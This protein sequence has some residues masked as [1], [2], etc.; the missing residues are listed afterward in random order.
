MAVFHSAESRWFFEGELPDPVRGWFVATGTARQEPTRTDD[1]LLLPGC[2]TT[3]VKIR[4]G[5]IEV[6]AMTR[7]SESVTYGRGVRG[8][9]D[10]WVKWS[11]GSQDVDALRRMLGNTGDRWLSVRK[12]RQLRLFSIASG[13]PVALDDP[14]ARIAGGCQVELTEIAVSP[15]TLGASLRAG[16]RLPDG[17]WWS[18]SLEAFAHEAPEIIETAMANLT[19]VADHVFREPPPC[20]LDAAHAR[21]YPAWLLTFA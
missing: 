14:T 11:C 18:L 1:Y 19:E 7:A 13:T 8:Y 16:D 3:G 20:P 4:A 12:S 21:A 5:S 15:S 17:R 2:A 6:K 10:A 9:R